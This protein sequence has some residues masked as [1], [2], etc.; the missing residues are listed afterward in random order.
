MTPSALLAELHSRGIEPV[1]RDGRLKLRG[2]A[3]NI[4]RDLIQRVRLHKPALLAH[5]QGERNRTTAD[6]ALDL[7]QR[8]KTFTLPAGRM[9][10]ASEIVRSLEPLLDAPELD[11]A[12]ALGALQKLE[13]ELI[14]LGGAVDAELAATV[15][16]VERSFPG[17]RLVEVRKVHRSEP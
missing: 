9:P 16:M 14:A 15:A 13:R 12:T 11:S 7:L 3:E 5:L 6:E 1:V 17:A 8:L 2:P 10:A 4:T